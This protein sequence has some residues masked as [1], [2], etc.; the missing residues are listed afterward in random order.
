MENLDCVE[1][2]P[3][4]VMIEV[5]AAVKLAPR[6]AL[7]VDFFALGTNDLI[8]YMLAADRNNPL[9][10]KYYDPLHP[11]VLMVLQEV[12]EVAQQ[13]G[14]GLC[15]CGEMASDPA[16][17]LVLLGMGIREFS[18]AAPFIPHTKALLQ[19]LT[20]V[21][22]EEAARKALDMTDSRL[23]REHLRETL[24]ILGVA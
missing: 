18:M 3:L 14:K 5:P 22:A 16:H 1:T 8:Q 10:S 24:K 2:L 20:I 23:I 15:L 19:K 7:E 17:V 21:Q 11:A 9:V 4:G 12:A 6:L 13:A